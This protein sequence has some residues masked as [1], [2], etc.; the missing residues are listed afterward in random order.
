MTLI[1]LFSIDYFLHKI[2]RKI[3]R[4]EGKERIERLIRFKGEVFY[5]SKH[6]IYLDVLLLLEIPSA[7]DKALFEIFF[8]LV[9][10]TDEFWEPV[11]KLKQTSTLYYSRGVT[12]LWSDCMDFFNLWEDKTI[13]VQQH[14]TLAPYAIYPR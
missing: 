11:S 12:I 14:R 2:D 5:F 4:E 1:E 13:M 3:K 10:L 8:N 9:S 6:N 7:T